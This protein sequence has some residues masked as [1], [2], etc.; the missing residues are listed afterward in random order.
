MLIHGTCVT[1]K[2][3]A[4]LLRGEPGIG[5]SSLA[6]DL[7]DRG[8]PLVADDQVNIIIK[9]ILDKRKTQSGKETPTSVTMITPVAIGLIQIGNT[10][11]RE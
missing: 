6:L 11:C 8:A 1:L 2:G 4:V 5:K 10:N 7:I 3:K 9:E